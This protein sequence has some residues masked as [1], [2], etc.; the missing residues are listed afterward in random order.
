VR[1]TARQ[2]LP[3][4]DDLVAVRAFADD[5]RESPPS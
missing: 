3:A 4:F 1:P 5:H 2:L